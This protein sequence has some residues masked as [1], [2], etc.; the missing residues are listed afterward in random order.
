MLESNRREFFK[1]AAVTG[2]ALA[3]GGR[4]L[5]ADKPAR[6]GRVIG[7]N[8]RINV[9]FIGVGGRGFY[10]AERFRRYGEKH[11]NSCQLVA[12]CDVYQKRVTAAKENFK[13]DGTLDYREILARKDVDAVVVATPDHWHARVALAAMEQG[14][15][16]YSKSRCA[17]PSRK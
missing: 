4:V 11:E 1:A 17:T 2:A 14:K 6:T 13:V 16:V 7:A 12:V 5:A 15:D 8:D 3:A 10:V 9:A